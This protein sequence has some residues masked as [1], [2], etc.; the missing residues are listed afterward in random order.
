MHGRKDRVRVFFK[1][2]DRQGPIFETKQTVVKIRLDSDRGQDSLNSRGRLRVIEEKTWAK[3]RL[4]TKERP[5]GVEEKTGD[6]VR[7]KRQTVAN[8]R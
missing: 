7:L 1:E 4:K 6:N 3:T 8:I 2:T 5:R